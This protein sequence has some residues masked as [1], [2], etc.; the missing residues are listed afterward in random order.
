[1][2]ASRRYMPGFQLINELQ[3]KRNYPVG[4]GVS[5]AIGDL[6]ILT[7]G[8]IAL[9]TTL[10]EVIPAGIAMQTNTAAEAVANGTVTCD[11]IPC[12]PQ[13]QFMVP[14]EATDLITVAQVGTLYDL[15]TEDGIDE[16]DAVTLGTG[17][18]VDEV[19]VSSGAVAANAFGYAIGH[20]EYV[21]AS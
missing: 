8:Y 20:F 4:I 11:V 14:C 13:Y 12:L 19:D 16:G 18:F 21:A 3:H 7:S 17:F 5:I 2:S 6:L 10:Q 9:G 15:Q 1:M